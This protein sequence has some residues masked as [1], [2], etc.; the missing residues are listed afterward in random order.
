MMLRKSTG[1]AG[2]HD[3][4]RVAM[5]LAFATL[6]FLPDLASTQTTYGPWNATEDLNEQ[7]KTAVLVCKGKGKG[8]L[9]PVGSTAKPAGRGHARAVH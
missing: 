8:I 3:L 7:R 5:A 4:R 9:E 2:R 6:F 1:K